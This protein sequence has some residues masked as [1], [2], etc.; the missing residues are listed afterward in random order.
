MLA[1]LLAIGAIGAV[2]CGGGGSGGGGGGGQTTPATTAG[3]Y[4]FTVTGTDS[5]NA[6]ITTSTTVVVTVQ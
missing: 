3:S 5:V 4:T 1:L 6:Q 2:G